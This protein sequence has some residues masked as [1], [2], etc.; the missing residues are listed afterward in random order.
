MKTS[1]VMTLLGRDQ[2]GIVETIAKVV[3]D[4][5][6]NWEESRMARLSGRFA[7]FIRIS[8]PAAT[9]QELEDGLLALASTGLDVRV[10]RSDDDES[11]GQASRASLELV[12][13]DRP[14]ILREI[15]AALASKDVNV[16]RLETHCGSAPMSGE[17]LFH[18]EADLLCPAGL[19]FEN[20]R[21]TLERLGQ[22]M[23]VEINIAEPT[24]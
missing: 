6:A 20:L 12:G 15:T 24:A 19:D 10:D 18:A 2:P 17:M 11:P 7:G 3:A 5:G 8:A 4:H 9:A 22:D 14:G 21:E 1:F 13:Q 23:M 16:I